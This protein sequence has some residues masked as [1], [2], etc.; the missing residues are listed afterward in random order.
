MSISK[1]EALELLSKYLDTC[2]LTEIEITATGYKTNIT[3]V[4][5]TFVNTGQNVTFVFHNKNKESC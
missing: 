4:Y 2:Y 1:E 3:G 5:P